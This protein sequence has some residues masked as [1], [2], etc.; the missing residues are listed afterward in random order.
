[1]QRERGR[2]EGEGGKMEKEVNEGECVTEKQV[3]RERGREKRG[4]DP[5]LHF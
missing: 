3:K 5:M 1:M 4:S 2:G